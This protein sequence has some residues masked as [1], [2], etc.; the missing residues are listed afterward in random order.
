MV[1]MVVALDDCTKSVMIAPQNVPWSGVAAAFANTPR[2]AVPARALSPSVITAMPRRKRPT[3]PITEIIVVKPALQL[4]P[5]DKSANVAGTTGLPSQK[6][7]RVPSAR[8][9]IGNSLR[10]CRQLEKSL[11]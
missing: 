2:K 8:V 9:V 10:R 7:Q 5:D 3:P 6:G 11:P 4:W 1:V